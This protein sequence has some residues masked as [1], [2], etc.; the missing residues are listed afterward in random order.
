MLVDHQGTLQLPAAVT[1]ATVMELLAQGY[2]LMKPQSPVVIDMSQVS[3]TDSAALALLIAWCRFA[4][5]HGISLRI[6]HVPAGLTAL[7]H[8][9]NV[10][11]V[12]TEF[13][14]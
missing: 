1:F 11:H 5:Q 2:R 6:Q 3:Q 10:D 7:M 14:A 13:L 9:T 8:V 12:L 4:K